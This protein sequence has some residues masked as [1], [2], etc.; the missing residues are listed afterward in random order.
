MESDYIQS[1]PQGGIRNARISLHKTCRQA[2]PRVVVLRC[3]F[4]TLPRS[5]GPRPSWLIDEVW[6]REVDETGSPVGKARR[7]A[8]GGCI[9]GDP[10]TAHNP[11]QLREDLHPA[12]LV[13][14]LIDVHTGTLQGA[15]TDC[16]VYVAVE[17]VASVR[18][19]DLHIAPLPSAVSRARA[20]PT[21]GTD[22]LDV[23]FAEYPCCTGQTRLTC[24][25]CVVFALQ[26]AS[27]V[28]RA[29]LKTLSIKQACR[30]T[31]LRGVARTCS[32]KRS[33]AASCAARMIISP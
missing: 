28:D 12:P 27:C 30:E 33:R 21:C 26:A 31:P 3:R 17:Y 20:H 18:N 7:F 19:L 14:H 32:C 4:V 1:K 23:C 13:P 15:G 6:L 2:A 25:I 10:E 9:R 16:D 24:R 22:E 8:S 29:L 11:V 5:A